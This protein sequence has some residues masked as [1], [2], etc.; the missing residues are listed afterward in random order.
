MG[1]VNTAAHMLSGFKFTS[2]L[3][4]SFRTHWFSISPYI[5]GTASSKKLTISE[6][7]SKTV[8]TVTLKCNNHPTTP[9]SSTTDFLLQEQLA[10][11][12][13]IAKHPSSVNTKRGDSPTSPFLLSPAHLEMKK[14]ASIQV[15]KF[16]SFPPFFCTRP[17]IASVFLLPR[18][19]LVNLSSRPSV[20]EQRGGPRG[21][22]T[23][24][25]P[26]GP[27]DNLGTVHP[28]NGN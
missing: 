14:Y 15:F 3:S 16:W 21:L 13:L 25:A 11:C 28:L 27:G 8:N 20:A 9:V 6:S 18:W 24:S 22:H 10:R 12:S 17:E 26:S 1:I 19:T 4:P 7:K 2:V 23:S 5:K